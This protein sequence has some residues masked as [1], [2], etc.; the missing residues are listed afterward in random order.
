MPTAH[1]RLLID[2][3]ATEVDF[4]F[5]RSSGPGGQNVNKVNSK[6]VLRWSPALSQA[7]SDEIR[8][9]LLGRLQKFLTTSGEIVVSSDRFR[10][11][12]RNKE[13]C[14][15]KFRQIIQQALQKPKARKKT[16][17]TR[18]SALKKKANKSK[19]SDKKRSRSKP[20][21]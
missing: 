3:L 13:D 21:W 18:S 16:K 2:R 17:P 11:Q 6:A 20:D 5:A 12:I 7:L 14:M 10:D 15:E 4:S 9:Y 19:H 1:S 8:F